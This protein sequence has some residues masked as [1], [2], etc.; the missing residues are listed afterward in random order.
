M[1]EDELPKDGDGNQYIAKL[2]SDMRASYVENASKQFDITMAPFLDII[3]A[4]T[5]RVARAEAHL[6]KS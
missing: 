2:I 5:Q 6:Q 4:L 3:H 1:P